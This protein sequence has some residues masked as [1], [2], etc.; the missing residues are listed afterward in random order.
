MRF[1]SFITPDYLMIVIMIY[2]NCRRREK[3]IQLLIILGVRRHFDCCVLF[4]AVLIIKM[5]LEGRE[6]RKLLVESKQIVNQI[7]GKALEVQHNRRL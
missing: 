3:G 6:P 1:L 2:L 4:S 5:L 7:P